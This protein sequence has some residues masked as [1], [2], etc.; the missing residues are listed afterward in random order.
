MNVCSKKCRLDDLEETWF[1]ENIEGAGH[2]YDPLKHAGEFVFALFVGIVLLPV[3]IVI[4]VL[5]KAT[6]RGPVIYQARTYRQKRRG[7]HAV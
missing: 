6:S 4:A 1:L 2:Y 3:E 7:F 5:I